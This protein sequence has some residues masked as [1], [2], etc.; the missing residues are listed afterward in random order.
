MP[1][2]EQDFPAC[3]HV[4][5]PN[6]SELLAWRSLYCSRPGAKT[7]YVPRLRTT[8]VVLIPE[9]EFALRIIRARGES[10]HDGQN[11]AKNYSRICDFNALRYGIGDQCATRTGRRQGG[12]VCVG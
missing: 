11:R 1:E 6:R 7:S 3:R 10:A 2:R 5:F 9:N 4:L 8:M 12:G